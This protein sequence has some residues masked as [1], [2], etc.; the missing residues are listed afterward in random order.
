MCVQY[1]NMEHSVVNMVQL[2]KILSP[3]QDEISCQS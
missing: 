3:R 2:L 1:I